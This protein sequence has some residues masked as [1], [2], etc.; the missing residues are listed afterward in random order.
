MVLYTIYPLEIVLQSTQVE[1]RNFFSVDFEG[2]TFVLEM[3]N[4]QAQI[5]RLVSPNPRDYLNPSWQ[6]G[7][8]F[9]F[10]VPGTGK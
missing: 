10:T 4:G 1:N 9:G 8:K 5:V 2:K 7:T 3:V 6:P